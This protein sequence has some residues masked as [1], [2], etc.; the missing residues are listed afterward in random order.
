MNSVN[1]APVAQNDSYT[2]NEDTLLTVAG[3]GVLANDS[4]PNDNPPNNLFANLVSNPSHAAAFTLNADGSFSY[5]PST[6]YNGAD[7]FTYQVT[8]D[9][10]TA[11][12]GQDHGNIAT[13]SITVNSVNDAPVA[14]NDSYTVNEDNTLTVTAGN[15]VLAND[16][17]PNDNPPNHLFANLVSNP[18]HDS[19]FTLNAD[20]SFTYV[21]VANFNGSDSFTYQVTDDGGT[22][23]GGQD[24]GNIATVFITVNS[25]NDA[26]VAQN[27]SYTVNEDTLLTVAGP[28][29]LANDSDPNDNP[30]NNLFANE[31]SSPSHVAVL[32]LNAMAASRICLR[33][34]YNGSDSFTYQ[35]T[36]DG[37]TANGGQ[38]HGNI[39]TVYI[40]V[41]SVND[42]PVAQ[43][44]SYTV[45]ED[46]TLT[47]TAGNGVLANDSD[48]NDNPPNHLFA[49]LVS[50]PAHDSSFTLNADGSF[51]YLP[52]ANFNGVRQFHLSGER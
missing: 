28:G 12:G 50:N 52:V 45:N 24:H 2:V 32:H 29:V 31:V 22:A 51:T 9:G 25:V 8:D 21:P 42:A 41:N 49:N 10:G 43:N 7:S 18:A 19:S 36:D 40:T 33:T 26:P 23:R 46:N 48:P 34:N 44:D 37:G 20:G 35:V 11:N 38:D 14:Q 4:D 3:P 30:P 27:D 39:A 1:D 17:D 5:L 15:G 47:V 6:N 13:V 16:S